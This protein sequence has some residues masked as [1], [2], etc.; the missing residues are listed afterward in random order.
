MKALLSALGNPQNELKFIHVAGTNGK[1]SVTCM[2]SNILKEAGYKV[3]MNTSPY[4]EE[5]NERLQINNIPIDGEKLVRYTNIVANEVEKLN[6][7]G[8]CPIEFEII[9]AIGF[10]YFRDEKCDYVVLE[11]GLGGR[12]DATNVIEKPELSVIC[13]IG[14]DHTEILGETLDKIAFE[15]AG[16][17][18]PFSPVVVYGEN[19]DIAIDVIREKA[20]RSASPLYLSDTSIKVI[21]QSLDKTVFSLDGFA[22]ELSLLGNHQIKNASLAIKASEILGIEKEYI[23]NGISKARW[24]CRFENMGNGFI[25]DGAHNYDGVKSFVENVKK[26]IDNDENIFIIGMLN[27]KDFS[28]SAKE[29]SGLKGR[30]IV[31]DVPSYRQTDGSKIFESMKKYIDDVIYIK[32]YKEALEKAEKLKTESAFVCIAGSLYLAGAV[33]TELKN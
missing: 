32:D 14:L 29:L 8:I 1:G 17:I 23:Q 2:L 33:R 4:I 10:L 24:K 11:C 6:K 27:D 20:E 22:Y 30:F 5:F 21:S 13:S 31:T 15:K 9:T 7:N 28:M 19:D 18:K 12:F 16:I 3:G 26:Y 25:I